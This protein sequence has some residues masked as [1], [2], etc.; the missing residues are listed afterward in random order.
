MQALSL[1]QALN[2]HGKPKTLPQP[3]TSWLQAHACRETSAV[4][5]RE[6]Q[7]QAAL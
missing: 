7:F 4:N 5:M 3:L 1:I 6:S 2:G